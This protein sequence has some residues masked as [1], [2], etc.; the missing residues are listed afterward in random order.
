LDS[1]FDAVALMAALES[2]N[3]PGPPQ[4]VW[5]I[6]WNPRCASAARFVRQSGAAHTPWE[7]P[8]RGKRKALWEEDVEEPG[9]QRGVPPV[10]SLVARPTGAG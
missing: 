5:L 3:A 6:K 9:L 10:L 7:R 4:L 8:H 2:V 1:V